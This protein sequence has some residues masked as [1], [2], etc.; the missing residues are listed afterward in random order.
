MAGE[1]HFNGA[2]VLFASVT[3]GKLRGIKYSSKA[4]DIDVTS[5]DD[6]T[7]K[8]TAGKPKL[9]ISVDLV[10]PPTSG[11]GVTSTGVLTIVWADSTTHGTL[12]SAVLLSADKTGQLDGEVTSTYTFTQNYA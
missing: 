5:N 9:E 6:T 2:S 11:V 10:G 8:S 7:Q 12:T 3:I 1:L 4:K